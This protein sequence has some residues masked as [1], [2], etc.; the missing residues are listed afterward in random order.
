MS[1]RKGRNIIYKRID[2]PQGMT[3]T[4]FYCGSI[5]MEEDHVPPV[6]RIHDYR[7][8][9]DKHPPLLV[10][11]CSWCNG[12]LDASLQKDIYERF[13]ALKKILVAEAGYYIARGELWT[14]EDIKY[15]EFTGRYKRMMEAIPDMA[16]SYKDRLEWVHWP[17]TI[18]G[19]IVEKSESL[20]SF[21]INGKTFTSLDYVYEHAR[22]VDKIPNKYL[23]AVLEVLGLSRIEYAYRICKTNPIKSEAQMRKVLE[24]IKEE[25]QMTAE[26]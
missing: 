26:K 14:K 8:L 10:P 6:S 17:V 7:A 12:K 1:E 25:L 18:D 24:D 11:C 5:A 15:G 20:M 4:C 19:S 22:K 9:Y 16:K 2:V 21:K 13:D 23:E 3:Y